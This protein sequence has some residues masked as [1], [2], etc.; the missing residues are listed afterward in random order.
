MDGRWKLALVGGLVSGLMGCNLF[1]KSTSPPQIVFNHPPPAPPGANSTYVQEPLE[2]VPEKEGPLAASTMIIF[3]KT[4]VEAVATDQ[5]KP[6]AERDKLLTQ[7][8]HAYQD[9]LAREPKNVDALLG[10][11]EMYQVTGELAK[12]GEIEERAKSQHPNNPKVWAWV[13]VRQAQAKNWETAAECYQQAC[14]LDPENRMYR[15]H[16]GFTLARAR[17]Y[18]EGYEWLKRSMRQAEA[19]YNLAM[20]MIHNGDKERAREYLQAAMRAD[21]A[22][23]AAKDQLL[24]LTAS[25]SDVRSVGHDEPEGR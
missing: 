20:M 5:N 12:L 3:A 8:R 23:V 22:F 10:L 17:R 2:E 25:G 11:G 1:S 4:W 18:D 16:L 19:R 21:P 15:I 7:A 9:V 24:A 14:R 13:A 6:A